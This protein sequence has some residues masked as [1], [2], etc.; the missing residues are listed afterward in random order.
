LL[1]FIFQNRSQDGGQNSGNLPSGAILN[2][3]IKQMNKTKFKKKYKK[4]KKNSYLF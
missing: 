4:N 1:K 2:N 3:N